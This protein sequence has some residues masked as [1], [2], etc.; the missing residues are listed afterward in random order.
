MVQPMHCVHACTRFLCHV[1]FCALCHQQNTQM[2]AFVG[3]A[4]GMQHNSS[5]V[6]TAV[7]AMCCI[8]ILFRPAA[9]ACIHGRL[10]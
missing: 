7:L 5:A 3:S 9:G 6:L 8:L 10:L 1:Q 2:Q 4:C